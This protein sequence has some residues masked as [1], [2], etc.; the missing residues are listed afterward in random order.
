MENKVGNSSPQIKKGLLNNNFKSNKNGHKFRHI[1]TVFHFQEHEITN[2][3]SIFTRYLPK[4]NKL[5]LKMTK[6][7]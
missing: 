1:I 6:L 5:P 3:K 2:P 7:A 4:C